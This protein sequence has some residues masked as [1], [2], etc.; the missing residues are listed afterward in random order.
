MRQF[1]VVR[2][3][4]VKQLVVTGNVMMNA[5]KIRI[6]AELTAVIAAMASACLRQ[7]KSVAV[8][9]Q[10]MIARIV[11]VIA[12]SAQ[13]NRPRKTAKL[14]QIVQHQIRPITVKK[15]SYMR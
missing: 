3:I 4:A 11:P 14:T 12:V 10:G 1:K 5:M 7:A 15:M 13:N 8:A 9:N 2:R 6:V